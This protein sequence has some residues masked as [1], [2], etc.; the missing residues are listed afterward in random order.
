MS[1][2]DK[3]PA[4]RILQSGVNHNK[5]DGDETSDYGTFSEVPQTPGSIQ[6]SSDSISRA[7]MLQYCSKRKL[8][9]QKPR[10]KKTKIEEID[11]H[12][13]EG[14]GPEQYG[15][16][17]SDM[18]KAIMQGLY[19]KDITTLWCWRAVKGK[20]CSNK[21]CIH[22]HVPE[23]M[24][25]ELKEG[26]DNLSDTDSLTS[27][28]PPSN[29]GSGPPGPPRGPAPPP[30]VRVIDPGLM[31]EN[32]YYNPWRLVAPDPDVLAFWV[33][34][35]G[36]E[37]IK[38]VVD[39]APVFPLQRILQ[40]PTG[41]R[42]DETIDYRVPMPSMILDVATMSMVENNN[43]LTSKCGKYVYIEGIQLAPPYNYP[44]VSDLA[45]TNVLD[46]HEMADGVELTLMMQNI[47][48]ACLAHVCKVVELRN[49]TSRYKLI[50]SI[51]ASLK[52]KFTNNPSVTYYIGE[53]LN[54]DWW[55]T[56]VDRAMRQR[57]EKWDDDHNQYLHWCLRH[58]SETIPGLRCRARFRVGMRMVGAALSTVLLFGLCTGHSYYLFK[59]YS[60]LVREEEII[61]VE[62]RQPLMAYCSKILIERQQCDNEKLK[63]AEHNMQPCNK[64]IADYEVEEKHE[65]VEIF[66]ATIVNAPFV[67]PKTNLKELD[68]ALKIRML[69][70][71]GV[72]NLDFESFAKSMIHDMFDFTDLEKNDRY[73]YLRTQYGRKKADRLMEMVGVPFDTKLHGDCGLFIKN[74]LYMGKT[75][76]NYKPRMIWGRDVWYVANFGHFFQAVGARIKHVLEKF[77]CHYSS[78]MMPSEVGLVG[79]NINQRDTI[80]E[81]DV[82]NW[83][84]SYGEHFIQMEK[85]FLDQF[86]GSTNH[87]YESM[88]DDWSRVSGKSRTSEG[89]IKVVLNAARRSGDLWTSCFNSL[90]NYL[91]VLY[92]LGIDCRDERL[93]YMV[94]GDDGV[95]GFDG[96][97]DVQLLTQRYKSLGMEVEFI[98][99]NSIF[100]ATYCSGY[101]VPVDGDVYW[102]NMPF[103]QLAKFGVNY[104]NHQ[105]HEFMGLLYGNAK[106]MLCTAGH[107]PIIGTFLRAICDSAEYAGVKERRDNRDKN[108]FRHMGGIVRYPGL[109]TYQWFSDKYQIPIPVILDI[110]DC[111]TTTV[112]ITQFPIAFTHPFFLSGFQEDLGLEDDQIGNGTVSIH[113]SDLYQDALYEELEKL[114][115][116]ERDGITPAQA[117][118]RWGQEEV[119]MGGAAY[120]P[121]VHA[122]WSWTAANV[123][124]SVAAGLHYAHNMV[125]ATVNGDL[126]CNKK[127]LKEKGKKKKTKTKAPKKK[128]SQAKQNWKVA[129]GNLMRAGGTSIGNYFAGPIGGHLGGLA[130]S[131]LSKISGMG[132]YRIKSNSL[133][134]SQVTFGN[135]NIV[136]ANREYI[137]E[138][139]SAVDY[140][141]I[142]YDINPGLATTFPWLAVLAENYQRYDIRG[143]CFEFN[144]TAGYLTA[145]QAQGVVVMSTQYDPNAPSFVNRREM[146]AYVYTTSGI[147]TESQIHCVEC[148]PRDRP[149]EDMY[150]RSGNTSDN[151]RFDD[152]GRFT[153]AVEG[154]PEED[155][156]LG[157]L[158]V[159]YDVVLQMPR[160][161]PH[162]YGSA[163]WCRFSIGAYDNASPLGIL[164]VSP[165]GTLD[166]FID[167][168][169][170]YFPPTL[171]VGY[172]LI[173][174]AWFGN[175]V[176]LSIPVLNF[177]G[178]DWTR[179]WRLD[180]HHSVESNGTSNRMIVPFIV[181]VTERN[182]HVEFTSG[183]YP[184]GGSSC[185]LYVVQTDSPFDEM[186]PQNIEEALK[187]RGLWV[188]HPAQNKKKKV[189]DVQQHLH[190]S[191]RKHET[192]IN[193]YSEEEKEDYDLT[194][195]EFNSW[196]KS[197]GH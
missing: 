80:F 111:I 164:T 191:Q 102:A 54:S 142:S 45:M 50:Q 14:I 115:L 49:A 144:S 174:A 46:A 103:R 140:T 165:I 113:R 121:E 185:D 9:K 82:S 90:M 30:G 33:N 123:S 188:K 75:P 158:W 53:V 105:P 169:T 91:I 163:S 161:E 7:P 159:T 143:L 98:V 145:T 141:T 196:K 94:L 156:L 4:C 172:Y 79:A 173:V 68:A 180:Q 83:D 184:S 155:V 27:D 167:E 87:T 18:Q 78:K 34:D 195:A 29:P 64:F 154:C 106:G 192:S 10:K 150:I 151:L 194:Y 86:I 129:L 25:D 1:A 42:K 130:G 11:L 133:M 170:L 8:D 137:G 116:A 17:T 24:Q 60:G 88:L 2:G 71:G 67:L 44:N 193:E 15:S 59:D 23:E 96:A 162:G 26:W 51:S 186:A 85:Y 28:T 81:C 52:K 89:F 58:S 119:Q 6:E 153:L 131:A 127:K 181:N 48:Q 3:I 114:R 13:F 138:I 31:V 146:E 120:A 189:F 95:G 126:Y 20:N 19:N 100:E 190:D 55:Y 152:L 73:E 187:A 35:N 132:D 97:V 183:I 74:E 168:N 76:D 178:C 157:E 136:V 93:I 175:T 70:K 112:G 12:A 41:E 92:C 37:K 66:G 182:A 63:V 118:Y 77:N 139:Y 40:L 84:G 109:D 36:F 176:G 135:G 21:K 62:N 117:G 101:F 122:F 56:T 16:L 32:V 124:V 147:V 47:R 134:T 43:L 104:F 99:R 128:P 197:H 125:V 5:S 149:L 110:E 160:I 107:M 38:V 69:S 148:D 65:E 72:R 57:E 22:K 61:M 177:Q 179:S 166:C 171:D 39:D 108:P